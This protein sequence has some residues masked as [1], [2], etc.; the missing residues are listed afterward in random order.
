MPNGKLVIRPQSHLIS[1]YEHLMNLK[2]EI[3]L[4]I[5]LK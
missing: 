1:N 3:K 2:F 4:N 5:T